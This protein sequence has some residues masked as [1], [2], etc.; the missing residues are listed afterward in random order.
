MMI[1]THHT[2]LVG[3]ARFTAATQAHV[4]EVSHCPKRSVYGKAVEVQLRSH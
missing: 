4:Q 3:K 2:Q 1:V